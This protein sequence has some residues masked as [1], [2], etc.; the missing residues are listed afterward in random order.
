[1]RKAELRKGLLE[2]GLDATGSKEDMALRYMEALDAR[3]KAAEEAKNPKK[4]LAGLRL[5]AQKATPDLL[6]AADAKAAK[7]NLLEAAKATLKKDEEE[8]AIFEKT[9][10]EN[11]AL[12]KNSAAVEAIATI[13]HSRLD[14]VMS[15]K[16]GFERTLLMWCVAGNSQHVVKMLI[17][18]NA[19]VDATNSVGGT[20]LL[21]ACQQ[22][23]DECTK[24]LLE[25]KAS[26]D[27]GMQNGTAALHLACAVGRESTVQ[28]LLN[29]D[30]KIDRENSAG[31]TPLI[32]ACRHAHSSLAKLLLDA[33]ASVSHANLVGAT[34]LLVACDRPVDGLSA[35]FELIMALLDRGASVNAGDANGLTPLLAACK[36]SREDLSV[37]KLLCARGA[38]RV[39][40][41]EGAGRSAE[42]VARHFQHDALLV[43]LRRSRGWSTVERSEVQLEDEKEERERRAVLAAEAAAAEAAAKALEEGEEGDAT[44]EA[45]SAPAPTSDSPVANLAEALEATL[46]NR[47]KVSQAKLTAMSSL[48]R[49]A[50]L[51]PDDGKTSTGLRIC[52][53]MAVPRQAPLLKL[54]RARRESAEVAPSPTSTRRSRESSENTPTIASLAA[55]KRPAS[56]RSRESSENTPSVTRRS[57][58]ES[59]DTIADDDAS[60][61]SDDS[62]ELDELAKFTFYGLRKGVTH[63]EEL[64]PGWIKEAF[65]LRKLSSPRGR[66]KRW[67]QNL[68]V[69]AHQ[70]QPLPRKLWHRSEAVVK[71]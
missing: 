6:A 71:V 16:D 55:S 23:M 49:R 34:P 51:M 15:T 58:R 39:A 40:L 21:L 69:S 59:A 2:L 57:S 47:G 32:T 45:A 52:Q 62:E 8:R 4:K 60:A 65:G 11:I 24:L 18:R 27:H 33:G 54:P 67:L 13:P 9:L 20:A 1:M 17:N 26:V 42:E 38:R 19:Q 12:D 56:R 68:G 25:A 43:W 50:G 41:V 5:M 30:A 28:L 53:M 31:D 22:G 66:R 37:V 14:L 29:A 61:A 70:P 46:P 10:L 64:E 7:P 44:D 3:A 35:S 36:H 63:W 48:L